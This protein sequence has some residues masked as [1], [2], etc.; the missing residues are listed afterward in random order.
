MLVAS[1]GP[2]ACEVNMSAPAQALPAIASRERT[3]T[4]DGGPPEP[5]GQ[6]KTKCKKKKMHNAFLHESV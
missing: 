6:R 1:T 3:N 5:P 2:F 4:Y